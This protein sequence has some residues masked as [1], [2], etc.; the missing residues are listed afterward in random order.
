MTKK[1]PPG[2]LYVYL[3]VE[4][5]EGIRRDGINL[6]ST[7]SISY[8][9]AILG[10]VVQFKIICNNVLVILFMMLLAHTVIAPFTM[11]HAYCASALSGPNSLLY[12][13]ELSE[14]K[15]F[16]WTNLIVKTVEGLTTLQIP[17]GTQPGDILVLAKKGVPKINKPSIRGDH[18][19]TIK[20]AIPN[21]ISVKERELLEELALLSNTTASRSRTRP[22]TQPVAKTQTEVGTVADETVEEED[23]SDPWKKLKDFAGS[24]ANG[25]LKW[26]RDNL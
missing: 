6:S 21:R 25:A 10:T 2:D 23:S 13:S 11:S 17:P 3:D 8:L 15:F 20:V 5:I 1:G 24:V 14:S 19:F 18:V 26:L 16:Y 7:V 9:D 22:K 12:L 4:E